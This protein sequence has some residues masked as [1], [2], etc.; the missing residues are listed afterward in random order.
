MGSIIAAIAM[1]I[2]SIAIVL[3]QK[4]LFGFGRVII[5]ALIFWGS[6]DLLTHPTAPTLIKIMSFSIV[7]GIAV[8]IYY[9]ITF[10]GHLAFRP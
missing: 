10:V 6:F 5:T 8:A 9:V 1:M 3:R 4:L 7:F 2:L